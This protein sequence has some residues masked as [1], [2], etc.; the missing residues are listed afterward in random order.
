MQVTMTMAAN[1]ITFYTPEKFFSFFLFIARK[2]REI[3]SKNWEAFMSHLNSHTFRDVTGMLRTSKDRL[4]SK[5]KCPSWF[6][7]AYLSWEMVKKQ[8]AHSSMSSDDSGQQSISPS[9]VQFHLFS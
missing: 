8:E 5:L 6:Q 9:Q 4:H 1:S 7:A 3:M 2:I